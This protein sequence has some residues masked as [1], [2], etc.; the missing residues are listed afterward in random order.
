MRRHYLPPT[1]DR[2]LEGLGIEGDLE[3][4]G[5]AQ[6]QARSFFRVLQQMDPDERDAVI[7]LIQFACPEDLPDNLH[8][9]TDLLR[10]HTGKS[11]AK[12]KQLLGGV[13]SL[14]F[15]CSIR[16]GG[17]HEAHM[18]G[19]ILG[20]SNFFYLNWVDLSDGEREFP[21]M[22]VA[23]EMIEMATEN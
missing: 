6:S 8:I 12:L 5:H 3:A 13:R 20:E 23:S 14:G 2:L 11:V 15:E 9:N 22:F 16:E 21:E 18:P 17:E 7:S 19:T 1:L 4:Q 10:R